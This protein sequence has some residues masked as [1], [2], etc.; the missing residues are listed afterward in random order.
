M[1]DNPHD[2][3]LSDTQFTENDMPNLLPGFNQEQMMEHERKMDGWVNLIVFAVVFLALVPI[4]RWG[5]HLFRTESTDHFLMGLPL[6][7]LNSLQP[8]IGTTPPPK[9]S[10]YMN[11]SI[12]IVLWGPWD[13]ISCDLLQKISIQLQEAQKNKNF[14]IIP[15]VYFA[16]TA[17]PIPWYEMDREQRQQFIEQKRMEEQRLGQYVERSFRNYGFFFP[18]VWWDPADRFRLDMTNMAIEESKS[19]RRKVDGFGFPTVIY[20]EN[21]VIR[22]VWSSNS[23]QDIQEITE[24]LK[25]IAAQK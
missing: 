18:S 11:K 21:G 24:A 20:A 10:D 13:D 15:I 12:M 6:C 3:F 9:S 19:L 25:L 2:K 1:K 17:E 5:H 14:R 7:D 23:V 4:F 8:V 22:N 16:R